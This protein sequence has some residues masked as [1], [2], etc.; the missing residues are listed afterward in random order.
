MYWKDEIY[1]IIYLKM[2]FLCSLVRHEQEV[3]EAFFFLN[4]CQI[5][6]L[7]IM[8]A[9]KNYSKKNDQYLTV[10]LSLTHM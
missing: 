10:T 9:I 8:T 3:T 1:F 5:S 2:I 7:D 4:L 6:H